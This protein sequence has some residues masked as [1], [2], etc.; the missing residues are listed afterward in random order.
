MINFIK[1]HIH[2]QLIYALILTLFTGLFL[3]FVQLYRM[4]DIDS[5]TEFLLT[6]PDYQNCEKC[7]DLSGIYLDI[8]STNK[9]NVYKATDGTSREFAVT[10]ADSISKTD[11]L[12]E[13]LKTRQAELNSE[14]QGNNVELERIEYFK[15]VN[16][17]TFVTFLIYDTKKT[18]ETAL[19]EYFSTA[20]Q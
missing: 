17:D 2:K 8:S 12:I 4:P 1:K 14:F 20:I 19:H 5:V 16:V 13:K 9:I 7:E 18:A 6:I 3:I 15:I 10:Q 11:E